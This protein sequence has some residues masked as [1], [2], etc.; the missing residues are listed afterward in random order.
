[1][2]FSRSQWELVFLFCAVYV[3]WGLTDSIQAPFFPIE[4]EEKGASPSEYGA[5]FGIIHLAMF[6]FGPV[7][8]RFMPYLGVY[9]VF[10]F[11][12]LGTAACGCLFGVLTYLDNTWAF[13]GC[14]YG[15]RLLEGVAEAG[16]WSS[17]LTILSNEFKDHVTYVYSL[18][19]ASFGFAEILGPSLGGTLFE[20]GGFLLPFEF[21]GILC[22]LVGLIIIFRLPYLLTHSISNR[23]SVS[24]SSETGSKDCLSE[25]DYQSEVAS[26]AESV[27]SQI[28]RTKCDKSKKLNESSSAANDYIRLL[29]SPMVLLALLGTIFSATCQGFIESFLEEYLKIFNLSVTQIGLSFLA[30]SVPYMIATP[31][32][33]WL[34]DKWVQPELVNPIGHLIIAASLI[35]IGPVDYT[36]LEPDYLLTLIGLGLIGV[37]TAATITS[38]FALAQKHA[39]IMFET[40]SADGTEDHSSMI[41]GLWTSAFA[42]GNFIGP[43]AGGPLVTWLGFTGTTP[44][45]QVWAL[46]MAALDCVVLGCSSSKNLFVR[47]KSALSKPEL[48]EQIS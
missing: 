40:S 30:M 33:G 4:A 6:V 45:I 3:T 14:S 8:G 24:S 43:T 22:L 1:M 27:E 26:D 25:E 29:N 11:G 37:G 38:T 34:V 44:I 39:L 5:V 42:L 10:I 28:V 13:L 21:S 19:Q 41:S 18:T 2:E 48:Y 47:K 23:S 15:L 46:V 32:W 35:L 9:R 36:T 17:V 16:A 12:V 20:Y 31:L 7:F